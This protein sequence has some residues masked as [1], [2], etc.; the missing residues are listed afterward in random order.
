M[1]KELTTSN[2]AD[3]KKFLDMIHLAAKDFIDGKCSVRLT[4]DIRLRKEPNGTG[5]PNFR[6][7]GHR[8]VVEMGAME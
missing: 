6:Y 8:F 5:E 7:I 4:N 3:V 2:V 1:T